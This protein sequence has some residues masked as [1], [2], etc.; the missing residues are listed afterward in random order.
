M[1][2]GRELTPEDARRVQ[3]LRDWATVGA[4]RALFNWGVPGDYERCR[5]FY[6]GKVPGHMIDGWCATLHKLATGATPGRA[7]GEIAAHKAK[8]S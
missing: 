5:V 1:V 2:A 4:G 3:R 8:G 7:P 6:K